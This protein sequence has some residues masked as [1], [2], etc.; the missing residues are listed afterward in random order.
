MSL[1]LALALRLS[2]LTFLFPTVSQ[3]KVG[4]G[5]LPIG[6]SPRGLG[7]IHRDLIGRPPV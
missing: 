6:S 7:K 4:G 2:L 1:N 5:W 3:K